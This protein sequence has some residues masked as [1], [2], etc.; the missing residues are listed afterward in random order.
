MSHVTFGKLWAMRVAFMTLVMAVLFFN[1][2]PL[3]TTP[4]TWAGPDMLMALAFAWSMRRPDYVPVWLLA[5]LF[6]LADLLLQRP[7][8]LWAALMLLA[9]KSLQSRSRFLRNG[10]FAAEWF[11]AGALM[12]IVM[13]GYRLVLVLSLIDLPDWRLSGFELFGTIAIYP[14]AALVTKVM[15]GR[16]LFSLQT[17]VRDGI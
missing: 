10:G 1:L 14:V 16:R 3:Q 7:P 5:G 12:V 4:R 13:L 17:A 6:L 2:L 8:G 15:L 9:C 11:A